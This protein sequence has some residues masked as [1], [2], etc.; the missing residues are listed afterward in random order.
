MLFIS[1]YGV[2]FLVFI[3]ILHSLG[4]ELFLI[5]F[6]CKKMTFGDIGALFNLLYVHSC[7]V[8]L[9]VCLYVV[10]FVVCP[11]LVSNVS[12]LP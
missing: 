8:N 3:F 6:F 5:Y 12:S 11:P 2:D 9:V 7:S 10:Y 1:C 4:I